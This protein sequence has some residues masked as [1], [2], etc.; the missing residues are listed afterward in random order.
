M[1]GASARTRPMKRPIRIVLPPWRW[2]YDSTWA[3]RC[4]VIRTFGPCRITKP[5][6]SRWPSRK[7]T[8]SPAQAQNQTMAS[9]RTTEF[10]PW[11]ASAPPMI[12]AV[13]PGKTRPTKAPVSANASRP[14]KH[15]R[16][17]AEIG[18]HVLEPALDVQAGGEP[19]EGDEAADAGR[20]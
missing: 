18:R 8:V 3:K 7:L 15:V 16:E 5:R 13:S 11:P 17:V 4:S 6:P 9:I 20:R 1:N 12:T 10:S 14:T 2:K 19:L